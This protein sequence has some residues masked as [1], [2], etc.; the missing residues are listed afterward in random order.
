MSQSPREPGRSGLMWARGRRVGEAGTGPSPRRAMPQ[1]PLIRAPGKGGEEEGWGRGERA[2][3]RDSVSLKPEDGP[4]R[5]TT[6]P[7]LQML[8]SLPSP[9]ARRALHTPPSETKVIR[10]PCMPDAL[11][12]WAGAGGVRPELRRAGGGAGQRQD[13]HPAS[14]GPNP[15]RVRLLHLA[16]AQGPAECQHPRYLFQSGCS[17]EHSA[18]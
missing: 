8:S 11:G 7:A 2:P 10:V 9:S 3:A 18:P 5:R 14:P 12:C 16:P 13:P 17:W 6:S 1:R 15:A 4:R